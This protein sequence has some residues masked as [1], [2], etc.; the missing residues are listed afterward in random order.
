[1]L[2]ELDVVRESPLRAAVEC[3]PLGIH[4]V[5]LQAVHCID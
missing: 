2:L 4:E 1:M 3:L 5:L